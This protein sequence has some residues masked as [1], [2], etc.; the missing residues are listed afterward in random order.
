MLWEVPVFGLFPYKIE[1]SDNAERCEGYENEN[2]S[3]YWSANPPFLAL[4][5]QL[6]STAAIFLLPFC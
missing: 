1:K 3:I 6:K 5:E 4:E 2:L